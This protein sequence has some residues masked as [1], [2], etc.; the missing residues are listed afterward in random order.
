M[1]IFKAKNENFFKVWTPEMAY[2]LGFFTADGNM[3]RNKRGAHFISFYS[4]DKVI[5]E[6][7]KKTMGIE[8]KLSLRISNNE[9]WKNSYRL[10]IGSKEIFSDLLKLGLIPN[11]SKIMDLPNI[12]DKYFSHFVRGYFDGDGCV[13]FGIYSRKDGNSKKFMLSSYFTS[14]SNLLLNNLLSKLRIFLETE[15]GFINNKNRGFDLVFSINDSKKLFSFMYDDKG[16][17]FL[18]RKYKKFKEG[19]KLSK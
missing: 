18:D 3:I 10:Q 13:H 14:G 8:H 19:L 17:L 5:L 11:K 4:T 15:Q 6:D 7:I 16:I 9:K 2:V 1:P 12:P